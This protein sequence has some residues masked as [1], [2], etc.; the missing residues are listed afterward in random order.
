MQGNLL[1]LGNY[2]QCIGINN[3][4]D[5]MVI[6]GKYCQINI[7]LSALKNLGGTSELENTIKV[8]DKIRDEINLYERLHNN[9]KLLNG[10][11]SK[12]KIR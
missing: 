4:I 1:D 11:Q 12:K 8:V 7:G 2:H 10:M 6:D 9:L 5:D 3:E